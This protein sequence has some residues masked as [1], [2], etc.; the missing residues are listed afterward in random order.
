MQ[1][2]GGRDVKIHKGWDL[3]LCGRGGD[4]GGI[5]GSDEVG[6]VDGS[7]GNSGVGDGG[8][9]I[10]GRSGGG[11]CECRVWEHWKWTVQK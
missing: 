2:L 7:G 6:G 11:R 3:C 10:V 9:C 8:K 5:D 4:G 1:N